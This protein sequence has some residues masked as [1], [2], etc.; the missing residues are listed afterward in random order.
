MNYSEWSAYEHGRQLIIAANRIARANQRGQRVVPPRIP[1]PTCRVAYTVD[2]EFVGR[3]A[4]D[5]LVPE[6]AVVKVEKAKW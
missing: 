2:G 1:Q 6:G 4:D 3:L 5:D